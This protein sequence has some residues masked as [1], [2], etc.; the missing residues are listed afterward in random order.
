MIPSG[1]GFDKLENMIGKLSKYNIT[2]PILAVIVGFI[3]VQ[4]M[5]STFTDKFS[6]ANLLSIGT[7][8]ISKET[9]VVNGLVFLFTI[10]IQTAFALMLLNIAFIVMK[11]VK[12]RSIAKGR[13]GTFQRLQM[14]AS[15]VYF[16]LPFLFFCIIF[17][18][19]ELGRM[20]YTTEWMWLFNILYIFILLLSY[21][22]YQKA[23]N[24]RDREW[25]NIFRLIFI[26]L[27]ALSTAFYIYYNGFAAQ[28]IKISD[29]LDHK[30]SMVFVKVYSDSPESPEPFLKLD[31]SDRFF[32]GYHYEKK[33]GHL[34]TTYIIPT[35]KI[36]KIEK[37]DPIR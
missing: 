6:F 37:W 36:K 9:Y 16:I 25:E 8:P 27:T 7:I 22:L 15:G 3:Y 2:Y 11:R 28:L 1:I 20:E 23:D 14:W 33:E 30:S 13:G 26:S 17:G 10:F 5:F 32:I 19:Y 29:A 34:N 21:Q 24:N 31:L 35:G 12:K 4:G 18:F